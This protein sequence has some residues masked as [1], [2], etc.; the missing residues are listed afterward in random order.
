MPFWGPPSL[1]K[2]IA[3]AAAGLLLAVNT[4]YTFRSTGQNS[5]I[6]VQFERPIDGGGDVGSGATVGYVTSSGSMA[7]SGSLLI[8]DGEVGSGSLTLESYG[9]LCYRDTDAGGYTLCT[10]LDGTVLCRTAAAS[11]CP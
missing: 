6:L 9:K 4:Y 5:N 8:T 10:A 7:L 3:I 11:E 1:A 2:Q